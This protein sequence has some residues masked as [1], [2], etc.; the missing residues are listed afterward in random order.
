L[1]NIKNGIRSIKLFCV[2]HTVRNRTGNQREHRKRKTAESLQSFPTS[3]Y[4]VTATMMNQPVQQ[5]RQQQHQKASP[6]Y[7]H[8]VISRL[9]VLLPLVL[10]HFSSYCF[11][12]SA[13]RT[14]HLS[15]NEEENELLYSNMKSDH[16]QPHNSD[17]MIRVVGGYAPI[18]DIRNNERVQVLGKL[19]LHT[20]LQEWGIITQPTSDAAIPND[21]DNSESKQ[22]LTIPDNKPIP[23]YTFESKMKEYTSLMTS[24]SK[25]NVDNIDLLPNYITATVVIGRQQ[26]VAGMNYQLTIIFSSTSKTNNSDNSII[27]GGISDIVIYDQFGTSIS[28][29]EW[30]TEL[31]SLQEMASLLYDSNDEDDVVNDDDAP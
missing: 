5:Q 15:H 11:V 24:S 27:M 8:I 25:Q 7:K 6:T 13:H 10:L 29:T 17:T 22:I 3:Y 21:T 16:L 20:L 18:N 26:V 4:F 12:V 14:G 28:V 30:G 31:T 2:P 9:L 23:V 19:V 1:F